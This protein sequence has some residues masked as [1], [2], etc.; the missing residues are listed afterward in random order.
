[1]MMVEVIGL[2]SQSPSGV[3]A[4][5]ICVD[6]PVVVRTGAVLAAV[7]ARPAEEQ[8][9]FVT[10]FSA[11]AATT[12]CCD[13]VPT[14]GVPTPLLPPAVSQENCN[15]CDDQDQ[16]QKGADHG[17]CHNSCTGRI[18]Q[19]FCRRDGGVGRRDG[20]MGR[21]KEKGRS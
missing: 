17:A 5:P 11:I 8:T 10:I 1:M 16:G 15:K 9:G 20:K 21:K 14:A 2:F 18:L 3:T 7:V 12:A 19:G 6:G 13:G 4:F